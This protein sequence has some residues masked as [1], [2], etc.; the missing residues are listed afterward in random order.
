[1]N[2]SYGSTIGCSDWEPVE[3]PRISR[4]ANRALGSSIGQT[5]PSG[6]GHREYFDF[7]F[8]HRASICVLAPD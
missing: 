2:A 6:Q 5:A 3:K 4:A 8:G 1:M 7:H